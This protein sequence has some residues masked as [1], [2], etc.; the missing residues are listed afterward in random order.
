M[1]N[2]IAKLPNN[3]LNKILVLFSDIKFF[4]ISFEGKSTWFLCPKLAAKMSQLCPG[5]LSFWD[6]HS[7]IIA[8]KGH[9]VTWSCEVDPVKWSSGI[10]TAHC[11]KSH[12]FPRVLALHNACLYLNTFRGILWILLRVLFE[13]SLSE[14]TQC[15][16]CVQSRQLI[17]LQWVGM[18]D[19]SHL[20]SWK[21]GACRAAL[22]SWRP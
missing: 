7:C 18:M 13:C 1:L 10:K 6:A 2:L 16:T 3:S 5:M 17:W 12:H 14:W 21:K 9:S 11:Q 19:K 4:S 15:H 20:T 8:Y 22:L